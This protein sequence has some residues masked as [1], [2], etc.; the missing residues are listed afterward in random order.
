MKIAQLIIN[1]I[2]LESSALLTFRGALLDLW[3]DLVR[4]LVESILRLPHNP[5]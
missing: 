3:I 1:E 4:S 5:T 2:T